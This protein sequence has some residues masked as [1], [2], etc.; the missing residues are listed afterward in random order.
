[1]EETEPLIHCTNP[2]HVIR[3]DLE[4][5]LL[6]AKTCYHI[7]MQDFE[8]TLAEIE[9]INTEKRLSYSLIILPSAKPAHHN[10][11]AILKVVRHSPYLR[12]LSLKHCHLPRGERG[13]WPRLARALSTNTALEEI[14][15]ANTSI[16]QSELQLLLESLE[17]HPSLQLLDF[18][19]VKFMENDQHEIARGNLEL[20]LRL[21]KHSLFLRRIYFSHDNPL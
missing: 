4:E 14:S 2:S 12:A 5:P 3:E 10:L 13:A 11:R 18:Q 1:M 21:S 19:K 15:C 7:A 8:M 9:R 20:F 16:L 6:V 17:H